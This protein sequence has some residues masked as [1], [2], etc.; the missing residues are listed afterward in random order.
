MFRFARCF[1]HPKVA[2]A[3]ALVTATAAQAANVEGQLDPHFS[4]DGRTYVEFS[5]QSGPF[6]LHANSVAKAVALQ[7]D[8]KT[9]V[10]GDVDLG[11]GHW[12]IGLTRLNVDG[13]VDPT[14]GTL[15]KR[16]FNFSNASVH[17]KALL[18]QPDG[19]IVVAGSYE[20]DGT[21]NSQ[22]LA[23]RFNADGVNT[24]PGFGLF[25]YYLV[26]FGSGADVANS[27]ALAG[28]GSLFLAGYMT[29]AVPDLD[30]GLAKLKANGVVDTAFGTQGL[31]Q[32]YF[33]QGGDFDD[34]ASSV[35]IQSDGKV[36]VAGSVRRATG[37]NEF[38]LAR[39]DAGTG[40]YDTSFGNLAGRTG[41][42]VLSLH[43]AG[44]AC[45]DDAEALA[46]NEI[47][48]RT[49]YVGGTHCALASG[50]TAAVAA[51]GDDGKLATVFNS[52]SG[53]EYVDLY[54]GYNTQEGSTMVLQSQ[55]PFLPKVIIAGSGRST[56]FNNNRD[57]LMARTD[58]QGNIDTLFGNAGHQA[59]Y[60]NAVGGGLG[61][62]IVHAAAMSGEGY[63]IL[64][65]SRQ[66]NSAGDYDFAIARLLVGDSIFRNGFEMQF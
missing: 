45:Y 39:V 31:V 46:I 49:I 65:G 21:G 7:A 4:G 53:A 28:D 38:G 56:T 54:S 57:F 13:S 37:E 50:A 16:Q 41:L 59:V 18:V 30:F 35:A 58:Y 14:F 42:S 26:D 19:K 10:A 60:F 20:A 40:A 33:D 52:G 11:G 15:G 1:N 51:F 34:A 48:F 32:I 44:T 29:S 25:G 66:A 36:V 63:L 27:V 22:F 47:S 24:D 3:L 61:D 9:V 8:G 43:S 64:A 55:G 6:L 62:D 23:V 5:T 12:G 17:A 2:V